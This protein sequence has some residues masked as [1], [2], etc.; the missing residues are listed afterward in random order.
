MKIPHFLLL[1]AACLF[2]AGCL[3]ES[4]NPLS[5]PATS[6]I[7][8]RFEGVY[9][10]VAKDKNANATKDGSGFWHFHYRG[11][12]DSAQGVRRTTTWLEI[13]NIGHEPKGG[14]ETA[15]YHAL[16]TKIAGHDYLSF[17]ELPQELAYAN[18]SGQ[19]CNGAKKSPLT[20]S[21]AR[22][23]V[24][25]RG[26]L[27]IWLANESAFVVAVKAGKLRGKVT[28]SKFGDSVTLTDTT[29][30]LAA[31]IAAGDPGKLFD[32][33]PMTFRRLSAANARR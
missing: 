8:P 31:F 17:I 27:R 2:F 7:D 3:P 15:R 4:I 11:A 9:Q 21:F 24:T 1:A 28:T 33:E 19:L 16:A 14:L 29:A 20:Y 5:T 26:D 30:H 32:T 10:Q 22:Y 13:V 12:S 6:A 23:E 25:W 18:F